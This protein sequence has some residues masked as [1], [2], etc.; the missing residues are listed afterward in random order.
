VESI[1]AV[2]YI[3]M[4]GPGAYKK[5]G[6]EKSPGTKLFCVSGHVNKPGVFEFPLG[7]PLLEIINKHC[8]GV[9]E[10][11]PLKAVIPG[12]SST[13]I[14]TAAECE[15]LTMDYEAVAARGSMLGSGAIIVMAEGTCMVN[16]LR[17]L[18]HFYAH[19]SCGQC[20]PCREGTGWMDQIMKRI[21]NGQGRQEDLDLLLSLCQ[22]MAGNTICPLAD[23]A[24]GPV[25]S[26][27][28]K[29]RGEF[30]D[31]IRNQKERK[32]VRWPVRWK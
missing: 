6:T 23:A 22:G 9:L 15:G 18:T 2:P 7:I 27:I 14:L 4:N 30:E 29:F 13:P 19:E 20:T 28:T 11:L 5:W 12:G 8:E 21:V 31:Y 26:F 3:I 10:G 1:A 24:V 16:A 17:V 32:A 25:K